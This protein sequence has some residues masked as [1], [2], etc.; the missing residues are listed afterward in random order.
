[1]IA[2]SL[3][4]SCFWAPLGAAAYSHDNHLLASSAL[5]KCAC[6]K[7]SRA[8]IKSH[9]HH[10]ADDGNV[11]TGGTVGRDGERGVALLPR[12]RDGNGDARPTSAVALATTQHTT[13][14]EVTSGGRRRA[15][16]WAYARA[17]AVLVNARGRL[18]N[19]RRCVDRGAASLG[20]SRRGE[21]ILALPL[22]WMCGECGV[23]HKKRKQ[24]RRA[25]ALV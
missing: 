18:E 20:D 3:A 13:R 16:R 15:R 1:M 25:A 10:R 9:G 2:R 6:V 23:R 24:P 11:N 22:P 4:A 14:R 8:T 7:I 19:N 17:R 12:V 5:K 21:V